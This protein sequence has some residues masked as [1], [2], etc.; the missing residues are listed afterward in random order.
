MKNIVLLSFTCPLFSTHANSYT[1]HY[2][3]TFTNTL[4]N[5]TGTVTW[6]LD[7]LSNDSVYGYLN[8]TGL[9]GGTILCLAG[10]FAAQRINDS[11]VFTITNIDVDSACGSVLGAV[12]TLNAKFYNGCDSIIGNY[13]YQNQNVGFYNL[14]KTNSAPCITTGIEQNS[15]GNVLFDIHPNPASNNLIVTFSEQENYNT[16]LSISNFFGGKLWVQ[17]IYQ[18]INIDVSKFYS[19][20]YFVQISNDKGVTTKRFV[21]E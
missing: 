4:L 6:D 13:Y 5:A 10:N 16:T 19:G 1:Y 2:T 12:V 20:I 7:F 11:L 17:Q 9:P 14:K 15:L 21:K 18:S 3:G 8:Y